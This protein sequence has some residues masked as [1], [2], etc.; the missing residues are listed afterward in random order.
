MDKDFWANRYTEGKTGWDI[1]TISK[2]IKE[3]I[4]Q[5][6]DKS[7]SILLPGAGNAHEAEYLFA[8]GFTNVHVLDIAEEPLNNLAKR[9]PEFPKEKLICQD[10]FKHEGRYDIIIE[11]TFYCALP[12]SMRDDYVKKMSTL[13]APGGKLTGLMFCFP[14]TEKGPPFGG[15]KEEYLKRFSPLF[16]V[17]VCEIAYNSIKP[18][19]GN[20]LWVRFAKK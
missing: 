3:Y 11:Q 8:E 16:D 17:E 5:L 12:P 6:D 18:R 7:V 2:P 19:E 20:E 14:L 15:S 10:F 9:I 1:G 13:L 4:D